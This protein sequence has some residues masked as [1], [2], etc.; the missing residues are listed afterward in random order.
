MGMDGTGPQ[1]RLIEREI[2]LLGGAVLLV[3]AVIGISVF[4]L[5]GELIGEAGPSIV[6]ALAVT[7]VPML[8]AILGLVQLGGAMPVAGGLY[9]YGSRLVGPFWGF[10]AIWLVIPAIWSTL[11]FTSIGFAEFLRF[12]VD[13]PVE[14]LMA[15]V[16]AA[17]IV[18]NLFGITLVAAVQ[19]VMVTAIIAGIV[20]FVVP[21]VAQ[22]DPANYTPLLPRG[23]GPALV[24]VVALYIPFQGFGMI[25]ELGEEL[26]DPIRNIPRVLIFGM[27]LA[28]ALSLAL[29]AVFAGLDR[30]DALGGLGPGGLAEAARRYLPTPVGAAI[31]I[32]AVLGALTTLNAVITSYSRTLMRA[33]RDG[34][35]SPRLAE[36]HPRTHVP[37]WAIVVLGLPPLLL[38]P[39]SPPVVPLTVFLALIILFGNFVSAFALWN[40]PVRYPERYERSIY[41]LPLWLL[42]VAAVGGA[43]F[44]VLL[45]L[46]ILTTAAPI[47]LVV[48]GLIVVGYGYYRRRLRSL[49]AR[50]IDLRARL[51]ELHPHEAQVGEPSPGRE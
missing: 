12:F 1:Y 39:I 3:G 42:R 7:V 2:G 30:W 15:A 18:L 11:L 16:L 26:K 28:V 36:I 38:V 34:I 49:A 31:A 9:V 21:G 10:V 19:L 6:V 22:V 37:H 45:W 24:A 33:S 29:I 25:V 51:R 13:V 32:A 8:L 23:L 48:A 47:A 17:F 44:A 27:S 40:L 50:G 43:V 14:L 46:A 4:I 35:I 20:A 41:R 5:P